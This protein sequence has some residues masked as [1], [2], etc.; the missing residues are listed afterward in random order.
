MAH[1]EKMVTAV[2]V[3]CLALL[4]GCRGKGQSGG[5]TST[6]GASSAALPGDQRKLDRLGISV[7]ELLAQPEAH[8]G[9]VVTLTGYLK[10]DVEEENCSIHPRNLLRLASLKM[11][12]QSRRSDAQ[13][14]KA[15]MNC[16]SVSRGCVIHMSELPDAS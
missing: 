1:H 2:V 14:V 11:G 7:F 12:L 15:T 6:T 10:L 3:G 9:Q 13:T 8:S 16:R 4:S 5:V